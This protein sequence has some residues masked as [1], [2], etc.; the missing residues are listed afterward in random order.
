MN[1]S[2]YLF[3]AQTPFASD[4]YG[5]DAMRLA[6]NCPDSA[7]LPSSLPRA[8][9]GAF[10]AVAEM[11]ADAFSWGRKIGVQSCI[12][13]EA[14]DGTPNCAN[15]KGN[16]DPAQYPGDKS[17]ALKDYFRGALLHINATYKSVLT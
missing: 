5:S 15:P 12:G 2:A 6:G 8:R 14:C 16:A 1:I 3:G 17:A 4:C 9:L 13:I 10:D 7:L 11:L